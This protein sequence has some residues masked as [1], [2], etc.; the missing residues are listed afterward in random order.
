[1]CL[2]DILRALLRLLADIEA[3]PPYEALLSSI[4]LFRAS[5]RY[6]DARVVS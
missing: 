3:A 5:R 6:A 2:P 4:V 1:M